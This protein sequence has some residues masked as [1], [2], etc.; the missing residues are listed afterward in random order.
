MTQQQ[1]GTGKD[2]S[3]SSAPLTNAPPLT[4]I[5]PTSL[6]E[7]YAEQIGLNNLPKDALAYLASDLEFRVRE[8]LQEGMKFARHAKRDKLTVRDLTMAMDKIGYTSAP[9]VLGGSSGGGGGFRIGP[10]LGY[11]SADPL[12]FKQVPGTAGLFYESN[13]EINVQQMLKTMTCPPT[14]P[15]L[16]LTSHWLSINGVQ[17]AIPE[18]P[19]PQEESGKLTNSVLFGEEAG[20]D[21]TLATTQAQPTRKELAE[22][23]EIK[24]L[25]RHSLSRELQLLYDTILENLF[26]PPTSGHGS[27]GTSTPVPSSSNASSSSLPM[28][29]KR[30]LTFKLLASDAGLQ[31]LL[32]YLIQLVADT[33]ARNLSRAEPLSI[34]LHIAQAL[35][36]NRFLFIEPYLHQLMPPLLTCTVGKLIPT[37]AIRSHAAGVLSLICNVYGDTYPTLIPRVCKTLV[38]AL[39]IEGPEKNQKSTGSMESCLG[40]VLGLKI[41]GPLVI[42]TT[43]VPLLDQLIPS[44]TSEIAQELQEAITQIWAPHSNLGT[45]RTIEITKKFQNYN[46]PM[47]TDEGHDDSFA[48]SAPANIDDD[49]EMGTVSGTEQELSIKKHKQQH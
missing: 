18:N 8:L 16:T 23:A 43:L 26:G 37:K 29:S 15:P 19:T 11:E 47:E 6:L 38:S 10:I 32:P 36:E 39:G 14:P 27:S 21:V 30:E 42:E 24:A 17:P 12:T 44:S 41:L 28:S 7:C 31:P 4:S 40:A 35:I 20:K 9:S 25:A 34:A 46:S 22:D 45:V 1:A 5:I 48:E 13:E 49:E 2:T 3:A 33:V